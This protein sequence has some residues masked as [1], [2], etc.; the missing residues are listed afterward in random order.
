MT[1]SANM[2]TDSRFLAQQ[3]HTKQQASH[4][5]VG[6]Q[7]IPIIKNVLNREHIE[8]IHENCKL[9]DITV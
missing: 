3:T 4:S 7:W 9:N 1:Y 8:Q 2:F 6:E 5:Q